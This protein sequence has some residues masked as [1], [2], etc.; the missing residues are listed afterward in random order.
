MKMY[1]L[2]RESI[3]LG[4]AM[5]AVGHAV[6]ACYDEYEDDPDM[7]KWMD[8]SFKKVVCKVNDKEFEKAKECHSRVIMTESALNGEETAIAFVPKQDD[9]WP[10]AFYFYRLYK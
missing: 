3:P 9:E 2:I 6:L 8:G 10:K 5:S 1:I 7:Q 4:I